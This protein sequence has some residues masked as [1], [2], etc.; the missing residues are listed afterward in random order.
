VLA[1]ITQPEEWMPGAALDKIPGMA[2]LR[3]RDSTVS[4][5]ELED[6]ASVIFWKW[7]EARAT[8]K[9]ENL[10][11]FCLAKPDPATLGV[12]K[13]QIS[14]PT[15]GSSEV[16]KVV[17]GNPGQEGAM[18]LAQIE[19]RWSAGIDGKAPEG[20]IHV[21]ALQRL[22]SVQ[23]KRSMSALDCPVC[24]GPLPESD[25]AFCAYCGEQLM[26]G[27]HEWALAAVVE[28]EYVPDDLDED[29][30]DEEDDDR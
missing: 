28:G 10:T 30:L 17:A 5:Q 18:D 9:L 27:K 11:R 22:S 6:R 12:V 24:A 25:A 2:E 26:G 19:I 14:A 16:V 21:L 20:M 7:I 13:A 15:V 3:Q 8:G 4:R 1:E 23:S 29:E